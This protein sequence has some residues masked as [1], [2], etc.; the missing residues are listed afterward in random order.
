[1]IFCIADGDVILWIAKKGWKTK[2]AT[3]I[4]IVLRLL[5]CW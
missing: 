1:M 4:P 2:P 3:N 5:E